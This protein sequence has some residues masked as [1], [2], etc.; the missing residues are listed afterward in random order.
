MTGAMTVE[1]SGAFTQFGRSP[2]RNEVSTCTTWAMS[3]IAP[4][5]TQGI[6]REHRH[7]VGA[8]VWAQREVNRLQ[9]RNRR[10]VGR[11]W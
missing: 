9:R 11:I 4:N 2:R 7:S 8:R 6:A 5:S 10:A 1:R 3:A